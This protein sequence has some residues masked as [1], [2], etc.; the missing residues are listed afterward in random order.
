IKTAQGVQPALMA[1]TKQGSVYVLNRLNGK[2]IYPVK[3]MPVP[4]GDEQEVLATGAYYSPT[5]PISAI[6]FVPKMSEKDMWGGTPFDQLICRIKYRSMNYQ[7][8]YTPPSLRGSL[9]YPGNFGV[10]D[11]GG[12]SVDPV[13]QIAFVNPNFMAFKS[14]LVPREEV[15]H[16]AAR[17]SEVEGVQ[18]N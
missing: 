10:F 8:I 13:R 18:P 11:W 2:P 16:G 1:S 12:I 17:K 5:Q 3:E 15:A 14:K 7:G 9:V 4:K 6:N